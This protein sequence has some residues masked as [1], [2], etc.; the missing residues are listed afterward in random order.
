MRYSA[1]AMLI[2]ATIL[3]AQ[4][5]T[6]TTTIL[7][8]NDK[9][10]DAHGNQL[11]TQEVSISTQ[12]Y[13]V[14]TFWNRFFD[15]DNKSRNFTQVKTT[16]NAQMIVEASSACSIAGK[17]QL[18]SQGCSGQKPFLVNNEAVDTLA[19]GATVSLMFQPV[20]EDKTGALLYTTNNANVLYPL[21]IGRNGEFYESTAPVQAGSKQTFFSFFTGIFDFFFDKMV[22][23]DF[24]G[25]PKIADVKY[26]IR[27]NEAE[28]RRKRY[29]ANIIAGVDHDHL[30]R[31]PYGGE[32]ATQVDAMSR[33]NDPV[34]VLHYDEAKK[35]TDSDQCKFMFLNLSSDGVMCRMMS[36]FGMDAWMPFFNSAKIS[37]VDVNTIT[38][39]TENALLAA[40][41]KVNSTSYQQV[42][43]STD[44]Q[45]LSL[46]QQ[47]I[48][49]MMSMMD[50]MKTMMF[51]SSKST[52]VADPVEIKYD[53]SAKPMT[54]TLAV[55]NDGSQIDRFETF[56]L[57]GLRSTYGDRVNQCS[58]KYSGI[59]GFGGWTATFYESQGTTVTSRTKGT[60][61]THAE[62]VNWCQESTGKKGMFDYLSDWSTGGVFNPFNWMQGMWS[63]MM[64]MFFGDYSIIDFKNILKR[65]LILDLQKETLS[66]VNSLNTTT[67]KLINVTH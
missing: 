50:M 8:R 37:E 15:P 2:L 25:T 45:K 30:M 35:T 43:A 57:T 24:F 36:G 3:S 48:K 17:G 63:G 7:E 33:L 60:I 54:L 66:P 51:G 14:E 26:G 21:D 39:D 11:Y 1:M 52:I 41:G 18:P 58:V 32:S 46:L 31:R 28:D 44:T 40:A 55:T 47:M 9:G 56:K 62:W 34:S 13:E 10:M 53:L 4:S 20:K 12:N 16:A 59:F 61:N 27:S 64:T 6:T 29:I 65:G 19:N 42:S 49:P 22:G 38:I 5:A 23:M 67:I